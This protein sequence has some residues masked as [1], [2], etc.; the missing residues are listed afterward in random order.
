VHTGFSVRD[1]AEHEWVE[2]NCGQ[3]VWPLNRRSTS[4]LGR[5]DRNSVLTNVFDHHVVADFLPHAN[6]MI[7]VRKKDGQLRKPEFVALR[8]ARKP[9]SVNFDSCPVLA[10]A[11]RVGQS[12]GDAHDLLFRHHSH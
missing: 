7:E 12:S 10:D 5:R 4:Q 11:G 3:L 8:G 6:R 2:K 1:L 9:V